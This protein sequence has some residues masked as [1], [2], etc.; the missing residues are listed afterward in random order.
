[1]KLNYKL[2]PPGIGRNGYVHEFTFDARAHEHQEFMKW[3]ETNIKKGYRHSKHRPVL[4]DGMGTSNMRA[5]VGRRQKI[6][7][8]EAAAIIIK[9]TWHSTT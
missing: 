1:M 7:C 8:R 9:L 6:V 5:H 3:L 2:L 4:M